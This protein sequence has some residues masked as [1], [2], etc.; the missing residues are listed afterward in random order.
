[1]CTTRLWNKNMRVRP[2][3]EKHAVLTRHRREKQT[4]VV[5]HAQMRK[6]SLRNGEKKRCCV[7]NSFS[8]QNLTRNQRGLALHKVS[9]LLC[10]FTLVLPADET[11]HL[12]SR[13]LR[14]RLAEVLP[15]RSSPAVN[16]SF[17]VAH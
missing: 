17:A 6:V 14:A 13:A 11:A 8:P 2:I 4:V 7:S 5:D 9:T 16:K 15:S 10:R 12:S 1:M 3:G